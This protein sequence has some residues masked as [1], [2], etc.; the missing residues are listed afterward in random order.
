[1]E[2]NK[3]HF[4]ATL[5]HPSFRTLERVASQSE[6][7]SALDFVT[8][9]LQNQRKEEENST[10]EQD[11]VFESESASGAKMSR[12]DFSDLQETPAGNQNSTPADSEL[13]M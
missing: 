9:C 8:T 6:R 1:M 2:L 10:S 7:Q 5:L 3:L 4:V 12:L 13:K 11:Q